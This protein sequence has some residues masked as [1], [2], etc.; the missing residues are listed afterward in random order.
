MW[1]ID[2]VNSYARYCGIVDGV[3]YRG[4]YKGEEYYESNNYWGYNTYFIFGTHGPRMATNKE[5]NDF[6]VS[7]YR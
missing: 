1:H 5:I 6:I 2:L 4:K 3:V 7:K